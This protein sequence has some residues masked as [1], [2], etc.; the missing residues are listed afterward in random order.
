[1]PTGCGLANYPDSEQYFGLHTL[2][3]N[4]QTGLWPIDAD[5]GQPILGGPLNLMTTHA[6]NGRGI[7]IDPVADPMHD[8]V[9]AGMDCDPRLRT[10]VACTLWAHS[11]NLG[12]TLAFARFHRTATESFDSVY[13]TPDGNYVFMSYRNSSTGAHGLL[14]IRRPAALIAS[15]ST[16]D[17]SQVIRRIDMASMPQGVAFRT[18]GDFAVTLNEDGTMTKLVFPSGDF[19]QAPAQSAFASGGFLGGLLRVGAD[20]C[21]YAPQGRMAGGTSG[22]RFADNAVASSDS[23]VRICG[24]FAS[25]PGV[26]GAVWSQEPGSISGSAFADW[27]RNGAKDSGEP[28]LSNV[29]ISLTGAGTDAAVTDT[30]GGYMLGNVAAGL[31]SVSAPVNVGDLSGNP[32]P[33][34]INLGSGERRAGV[35]FPYAESIAPVC[36]S[37]TPS[38]SPTRADFA[39]QDL[40]G[41]RRIV[42]RTVTNF[43][44][45]V[46]GAAPVTTP[47]TVDFSTPVTGSIGVSATR[48][49]STQAASIELDA[50]DA[51][52]NQ[53][54]CSA[55][56][57]ADTPPPPPPQTYGALQF[58]LTG[59]GQHHVVGHKN[60]ASTMR[61]LKVENG[62]HGLQSVD[63]FVN[64]QKFHIGSLQDGEVRS[65]DIAR[66]LERGKK[67]AIL[68]VG[69]G[70]HQD[71]AIVTISQ[72]P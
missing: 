19:S 16:I 65:I 12:D 30:N 63:V 23:V 40:S 69:W 25:A 58:E 45:S 49:D 67:H 57:P 46:Q 35:D 26:A 56:V 48:T 27:N 47:T 9:Y 61:Y 14:V 54:S 38:G 17:D 72:L 21:I 52:G 13:F 44:V 70:H 20:G 62:D 1:M 10:A 36:T 51:F 42:V 28:G 34:A 33:L 37:T 5:T 59:R 22:V 41:L 7:D 71:S 32:T 39:L 2:M 6:G 29:Q 50:V 43:Q 11:F 3:A 53:V 66:A 55:N 68:M 18:A 60:L 8:I 24:G 31:Y 64:G 15:R 4:T